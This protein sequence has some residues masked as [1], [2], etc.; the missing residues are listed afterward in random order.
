M[1]TITLSLFILVLISCTNGQKQ[2]NSKRQDLFITK[3]S[4]NELRDTLNKYHLTGIEE[5][6]MKSLVKDSMFYSIKEIR[7][8]LTDN[9]LLKTHSLNG[10]TLVEINYRNSFDQSDRDPNLKQVIDVVTDLVLYDS[11]SEKYL[12]SYRLWGNH[13][14]S[15]V[16]S[17]K[18][19][20]ND[21]KEEIL[22]KI[23]SP[24]QSVPVIDYFFL[25]ISYDRR[26]SKLK[27]VIRIDTDNRDCGIPREINMGTQILSSYTFINSYSLKITKDYYSFNC[28]N[29]DFEKEI[30]N[31][32]LDSTKVITMTW[33]NEKFRYE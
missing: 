2:T 6:V 30:K 14:N 13:Y 27:Q 22:A 26:D 15:F 33:N 29:F 31:K 4:D 24:T 11:K 10:Q 7:Q 5:K 17:I 25:V 23:I 12:C 18:D 9:F 1:R 21:E 3:V 20:N 16:I 8:L 32:K 19:W 28:N